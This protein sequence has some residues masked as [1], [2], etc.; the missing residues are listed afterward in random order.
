MFAAGHKHRRLVGTSAGAI[1]AT[2]L[3]AGYSPQ[4][5]LNAVN[6]TVPGTG[7]PI[8]T[9]FLDAPQITDFSQQ[10]VNN[11]E[12]MGFLKTVH[13]PGILDT[14]P[15]A[16]CR[17][18]VGGYGTTEF[19]MSKPRMDALIES[20]RTAMRAYLQGLPLAAGAPRA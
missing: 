2:L 17:I 18:P 6:E 7:A 20:G 11:S 16:V 4:E 13:I 19:R 8:F 5:F 3:G 14:A 12:T 1:T 10:N 15:E 9:T